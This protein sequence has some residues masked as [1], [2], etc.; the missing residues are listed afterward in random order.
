[1]ILLMRKTALSCLLLFILSFGAYG[2][3]FPGY[4]FTFSK[5]DPSAK[6]QEDVDTII[7]LDYTGYGYLGRN[8]RTG[9]YLRLALEAPLNTILSVFSQDDKDADDIAEYLEQS[10]NFSFSIGP[11][12]RKFIGDDAIWYMGT[13][14]TAEI[15]YLGRSSSASGTNHSAMSIDIAGEADMGIRINISKNTTMRI[16]ARASFNFVTLNIESEE[17]AG[18]AVTS[19]SL[20]PNLFLPEESRE[21]AEAYGYISLGH[22]FRSDMGKGVYSYIITTP[23]RFSGILV[24]H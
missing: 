21:K 3:V 22:T 18:R 16:G 14:A 13:G 9:I 5:T 20:V 15:D 8:M 23:E 7:S 2:V 1:M 19:V 12:F 24:K 11:S 4:D 6:P 10:F 17:S